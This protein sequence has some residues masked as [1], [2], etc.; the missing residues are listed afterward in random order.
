MIIAEVDDL[1]L[2]SSLWI[3]DFERPENGVLSFSLKLIVNFLSLL[4]ALRDHLS[5]LAL[6]FDN[7]FLSALPNLLGTRD[8]G[9][10]YR[11]SGIFPQCFPLRRELPALYHLHQN[12]LAILL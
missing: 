1:V 2:S 8:L 9:L 10:H 7:R 11:H 6:V 12:V 3:R 4:G 5:S